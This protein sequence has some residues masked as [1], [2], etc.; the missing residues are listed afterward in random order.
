MVEVLLAGVVSMVISIVAGPKFIDFLRQN[1][2][3]QQIR[4]EGPKG[5]VVKQGTPAMG[6]LLIMISMAIPFLIFSGR[7]VP[8]VTAFFV[9]LG[10]A[11]I[12]FVDDWTK[13]S[14]R[15]S[16]GL[17]GRWKLLWLAGIT[18]V[19]AIVAQRGLEEPLTTDVYVPLADIDVPLS[20]GWYVLLFVII[21]GAAN[22]VNLTDGI[23]GLAA[24]TTTISIL[25]Y[26]AMSLV[27]ALAS[28]R[29]VGAAD[30]IDLDLAILGASLVGASI[31][32]LWYNAFPAQVFMGD[33]GSMGLG[34]AIAAFA[35]MT[36]T[37][38]L[39]VLIGGIFVIEALSVIVQVVSFKWFGRRVLLMAPLHHHFEMKAW[40]E[41]R[42]TVRFWIVS[43]LLCACGFVLYYRYASEFAS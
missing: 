26:T 23:D 9:T 25:T 28:I 1:E 15:R 8:A 29:A 31:G 17:A 3:G 12:G 5:H 43:A 20:Y 11:A 34:G 33:T 32:F 42:I 40:S 10:C 16:L 36:K 6:G 7:T 39:L 30:Q 18:V 21:A 4:E 22:G 2:F 24:G 14:R 19:V 37:E 38:L 41:T 13:V 27:A 35:I